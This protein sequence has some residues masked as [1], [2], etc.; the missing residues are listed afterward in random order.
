[1]TRQVVRHVLI[2]SMVV[3]GTATAG[4]G[5]TQSG[6]STTSSNAPATDP[7]TTTIAGTISSLDVA[8]FNPRVIVAEANGKSTTVF[9]DSATRIKAQNGGGQS[10][11][12][13][14]GQ[15]VQILGTA[16]NR[17]GQYKAKVVTI[18]PSGGQ[19]KNSASSTPASRASADAQ[20]KSAAAARPLRSVEGQK[21]QE[22]KDAKPAKPS[23]V[24]PESQAH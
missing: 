18:T 10:T 14:V 15:Q 20:T 3:G 7:A 2:F 22:S 9:L 13:D 23:S 12:L 16:I 24:T 4:F 19:N 5:E 21:P 11:D 17:F 6:R 1:M 8:A